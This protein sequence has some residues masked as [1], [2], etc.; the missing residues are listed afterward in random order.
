ML[1]M[2][3]ALW[4]IVKNN[5][6]DIVFFLVLA[7]LVVFVMLVPVGFA[8]IEVKEGDWGKYKIEV[9]PEKMEKC[10]GAIEEIEWVKVEAKSISDTTV[11]AEQTIHFKNGTEEMEIIGDALASGFVIEADLG[12]GDEVKAEFS[13]PGTTKKIE[14]TISRIYA[15]AS[16]KVNY[17]EFTVI[18]YNMT[19]T[20]KVYWDKKTGIICEIS[21]SFSEFMGQPVETPLI[22]KM[23]ATNLWAATIWMQWWF[24]AIIGG[25]IIIAA[26]SAVLLLRRLSLSR[27]HA[28]IKRFLPRNDVT[29]LQRNNA[30]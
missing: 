26:G 17:V 2:N 25:I 19:S 16:R 15:G 14:G 3:G 10:F 24:W 23:T 12:E 27:M 7:G 21:T 5:S 29:V 4:Y 22:Y 18:Q 20:M 30:P 13:G 9:I 28:S 11:T 8:A 6:R 1:V